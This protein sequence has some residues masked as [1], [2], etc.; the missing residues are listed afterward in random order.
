[1]CRLEHPSSLNRDHRRDH[2]EI[3]RLDRDHTSSAVEIT[4]A[5]PA[6]VCRR[7]GEAEAV[8]AASSRPAVPVAS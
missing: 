5:C 1:V 3:I 7:E 2:V 6:L 4:R 8:L